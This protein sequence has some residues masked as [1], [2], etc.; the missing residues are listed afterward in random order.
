MHLYTKYLHPQKKFHTLKL[1][2]K[3][4][5]IKKKKGKMIE[6]NKDLGEEQGGGEKKNI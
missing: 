2:V 3:T 6:K 4:C 1:V 5:Y